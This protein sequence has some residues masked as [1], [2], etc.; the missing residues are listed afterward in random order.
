MESRFAEYQEFNSSAD[1][2]I[3]RRF[4]RNFAFVPHYH[5]NPEIV[6][7]SSGSMLV[8]VDGIQ[9]E[10]TANHFCIVLP[11]QIHS[12]STP[13]NSECVVL[14][15]PSKYIASFVSNMSS[16]HGSSHVFTA[17]PDIHALFMKY[18]YQDNV[19]N[20]YLISC[21][22]YG[23]CHSFVS[24]C[25]IVPNSDR[26]RSQILMKMM[27]YVSSHFRENLSLKDVAKAL[28]YNYYYVSHFFCEYSGLSFQ[29]FRNLKRIEYA[30]H[31]LAFSQKTATD[32]AFECGFSSVRTFNRVF[33]D[34]VHMTPL[35]YR[36]RNSNALMSQPKFSFNKFYDYGDVHP[37]SNTLSA[38]EA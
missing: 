27:D 23:L 2:S 7:V 9:N 26:S 3:D 36:E 20:E 32:I 38:S 28:G 10:L 37:A 31:E 1:L 22:L 33:R 12:Y 4:Y 15:F 35:E 30:R 18:L 5:A 16:S 19:T 21:I 25:T 17:E 11:W 14:V 24:S 29:Q 34:T 13:V 8:T 6:Y